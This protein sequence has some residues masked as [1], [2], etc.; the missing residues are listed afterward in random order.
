MKYLYSLFVA[1]FAFSSG[2]THLMGGEIT[3]LELP[4]GQHRVNL[5]AYRDMNGINMAATAL[6]TF[7]G[8]NGQQFTR[9]VSQDSVIS[10][11]VLPMYPYGVEV[12]YFSDTVTFPSYGHWHVSWSNCCRNGAIQNLSNPLGES[13]YLSTDIVLDSA[14]SNSTPFFLVP[15]AIYLPLN[16]A[17]QYNPLPFDV[18]GDSLVWS[19]DQPLDD[20][21]SYCA[22]YTTPPSAAANPLSLDSAT[23]TISWTADS[24]GHYV[25]SILVEQYRNGV[26]VGEVRRDMQFIVVPA[27][28]GFPYWSAFNGANPQ[29][30]INV[31]VP[32]S[33][34]L[35]FDIEASHTDSTQQLYMSA[36]SSL[37]RP[38]ASN[39][40]FSVSPTGVNKDIKGTFSFTPD[41]THA[42]KKHIVVVRCSDKYFTNDQAITISVTSGIGL[43]ELQGQDFGLWQLYPNPAQDFFRLSYQASKSQSLELQILDLDGKVVQRR[44]LDAQYGTNVA[45]VES[46][47]INPGIYLV[48]VKSKEGV[49]WTSKL[50]K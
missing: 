20:S 9:V 5:I 50:V 43:E 44:K 27:G 11:T 49:L 13:M 48:Q 4:N 31:S 32:A 33:S 18:D 40:T 17:W 1:L 21:A 24:V 8:P 12:Y 23:G 16:T 19:I 7:S 10:G 3:L 2:A 29:D 15:A 45:L 35:S 46:A 22:G 47:S 14:S 30:T 38:G 6:F 34:P 41:P 36:Y 39:A 25:I 26:Y 37:L 42:H 28:T